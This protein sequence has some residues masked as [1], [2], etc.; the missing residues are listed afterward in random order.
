MG[1]KSGKLSRLIRRRESKR[2]RNAPASSASATGNNNKEAAFRSRRST[3]AKNKGKADGSGNGGS[4]QQL[5]LNE[6]SDNDSS[7]YYGQLRTFESVFEGMGRGMEIQ[8]APVIRTACS[9]PKCVF[10]IGAQLTTEP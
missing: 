10:I 1:K 6:S 8:W 4:N 9:N 2:D 3:S 5:L 7:T